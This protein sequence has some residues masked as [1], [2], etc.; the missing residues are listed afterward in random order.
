MFEELIPD[1]QRDARAIAD[2]LRRRVPLLRAGERAE[3]VAVRLVT[4]AWYDP[5]RPIEDC[6]YAGRSF[7]I[8]APA[9]LRRSV[10]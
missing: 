3:R 5:Q 1:Q 4:T 8:P 2:W 6:R 9:S 7:A 10:V